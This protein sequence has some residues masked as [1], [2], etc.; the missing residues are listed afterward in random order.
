MG[1]AA[2]EVA[3][4][5]GAEPLSVLGAGRAVP[6]GKG[7]RAGGL[8]TAGPGR[9]PVTGSPQ[10][11]WCPVRAKGCLPDVLD[12]WWPGAGNGR[13]RAAAAPRRGG[14][15]GARAPDQRRTCCGHSVRA[16]VR[17]RRPGTVSGQAT[18]PAS[19]GPRLAGQPRGEC[20]GASGGGAGAPEARSPPPPDRRAD[21]PGRAPALHRVG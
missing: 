6:R 17:A 7:R 12:G 2:R 11:E 3:D 21:T 4:G 15:R 10:G 9:H 14:L 1:P 13:S 5:Q 16:T 8:D 18:A 20:L 19:S